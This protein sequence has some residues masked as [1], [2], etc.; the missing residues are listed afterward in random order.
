MSILYTGKQAGATVGH[1]IVFTLQGALDRYKL[2]LEVAYKNGLT[3][4]GANMLGDIQNELVTNCGMTW[5][6]VEKI[7]KEYLRTL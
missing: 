4:G 2:A 6:E 7:E 1:R 5:D 3:I